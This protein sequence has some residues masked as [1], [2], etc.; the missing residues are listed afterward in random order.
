MAIARCDSCK[1]P[2]GRGR[3]YVLS[4][5]P[6]GFPKRSSIVC[7]TPKCDRV[8][9]VWLDEQETA[10]FEQ[11]QRIFKFVATGAVKVKVKGVVAWLSAD[12]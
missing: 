10:L 6:V 3:S 9:L 8:A 12:E 2:K 7:G 11:G 5:E 1:L 4:T